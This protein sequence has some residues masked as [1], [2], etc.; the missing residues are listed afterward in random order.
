MSYSIEQYGFMVNDEVR[1]ATYYNA[2]REAIKPGDVVIDI[3]AGTGVFSLVA[4]QLGARKVYA[5][6]TSRLLELGM[7]MAAANGFSDRIEWI[8]GFSTSI[9]LP[10]RADV[11]ISDLRGQLPLYTLHI[12]SLVD[13]R[14]RLLKPG[15]ILM[16]HR[17]RIYLALAHA[18]NS[19]AYTVARPWRENPFGLD[20]RAA[21]PLVVNGQAAI[22]CDPVTLV[23]EPRLWVELDYHTRTDPDVDQTVEWTLAEAAQAHFIVGWFDAEIAPGHTYTTSPVAERRANIYGYAVLPLEEPLDLAA[24]DQVSVR[25][26]AKLMIDTYGLTWQTTVRG[27]DGAVKARFQQSSL[28]AVLPSALRQRAPNH[29]PQLTDEGKHARF[30]LNAMDEGKSNQA[31]AE[32]LYAAFPGAFSADEAFAKVA[33]LAQRYSR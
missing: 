19:Y 21:L 6:E 15:G 20:M 14:T 31:I 23:S 10:E 18:P 3:G 29:V 7:E 26:I 8:R 12:P 5:I 1:A 13:A 16:P 28:M 17:D 22:T 4:C 32:A 25:M 33:S 24:G 27:S 2:M 11:I 9:T 30:I